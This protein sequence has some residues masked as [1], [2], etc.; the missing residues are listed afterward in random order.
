[1]V[2]LKYLVCYVVYRRAEMPLPYHTYKLNNK[3]LSQE[4]IE[5]WVDELTERYAG[6]MIPGGIQV[7]SIYPCELVTVEEEDDSSPSA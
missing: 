2:Y 6:D 3:S 4:V 7:T 1:M 5:K